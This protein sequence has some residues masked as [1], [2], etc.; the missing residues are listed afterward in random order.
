[1]RRL[2]SGAAVKFDNIMDALRVLDSELE[3]RVDTAQRISQ[4]SGPQES[5]EARRCNLRQR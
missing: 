4:R 2:F 3:R 1:M 5:G